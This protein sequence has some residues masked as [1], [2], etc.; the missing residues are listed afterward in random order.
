[1]GG[2]LTCDVIV[3]DVSLRELANHVISD[4]IRVANADILKQHRSTYLDDNIPCTSLL[5]QKEIVEEIWVRTE[6][7]GMYKS[8]T[9]LDLVGGRP[10]EMRYL[11]GVPL[12]RARA[13]QKENPALHFSHLESVLLMVEAVSRMGVQK[14]ALGIPWQP[15]YFTDL[16]QSHVNQ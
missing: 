8:S 9:V 3:K 6:N 16:V 14:A 15:T 7:A 1:M 12:E 11:F 5:C 13:L 4:I 10:L 2:G